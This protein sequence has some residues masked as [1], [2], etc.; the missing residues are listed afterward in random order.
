MVKDFL[1][2][3]VLERIIS[4]GYWVVLGFLRDYICFSPKEALNLEHF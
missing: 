2:N 1:K 3:R 4:C